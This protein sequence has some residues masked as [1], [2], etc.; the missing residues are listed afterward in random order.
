MPPAGMGGM[1]QEQINALMRKVDE[2]QN[3]AEV[4]E[5]RKMFENYL[6]AVND[7]MANGN[8]QM[9]EQNLQVIKDYQL[10]NGGSHIQIVL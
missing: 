5:T 4:D 6:L 7:A 9:A 3:T 8:W 1:S 10:V 2:G